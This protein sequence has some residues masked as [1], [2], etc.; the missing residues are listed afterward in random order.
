MHIETLNNLAMRSDSAESAKA[1]LL[2]L[3][4]IPGKAFFSHA[5]AAVKSRPLE[6]LSSIFTGRHAV[7][8]RCAG[9]A[10]AWCSPDTLM[11]SLLETMS[12]QGSVWRAHTPPPV[13]ARYESRLDS[14]I[15]PEPLTDLEASPNQSQILCP[16][17]LCVVACPWGLS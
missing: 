14:W 2:C 6:A 3:R 5:K 9:T 8:L 12:S 15:R 4:I 16:N 10:A 7:C 11:A 17:G 1:C 13:D